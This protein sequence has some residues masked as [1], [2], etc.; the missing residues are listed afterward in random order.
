MSVLSFRKSVD[1]L[2]LVAEQHALLQRTLARFVQATSQYA[3]ELKREHAEA[4]RANLERIQERAERVA[5]A[6][7]ADQLQA[8]FRGELR[9]YL[10]TSQGEIWRMR[11]EMSDVIASMQTFL[12]NSVRSGTNHQQVLRREFKNLD[13]AAQA[14]DL[15]AIRGAVRRATE[16][17]FRSY[18][19]IQRAQ[20]T[21]IAQLQDEIRHLHE[22][23]GYER[24]AALSDPSTGLWNR[25]KLD[26]RIK[27]LLLLNE[28][29]CVYFIGVP[30][31]LHLS[32]RDPR[33]G[34][35]FLRSLAGRLQTAAG[36]NGEFGMAGR[37]SAE[38]FAI[39]FNL[40]LAS[41]PASPAGMQ[42]DLSGDYSIQVE[43]S[44]TSLSVEVA[45]QAIERLRDIPEA[46]FYQELGQAAFRVTIPSP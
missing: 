21:V 27:E 33:I 17:A 18:E 10:D 8:D 16:T 2:D 28:G 3:I 11:S 45:V 22:Q 20:V 5:S 39:V 44:S 24:K 15:T 1:Q 34:P 12:A 4:F 25:S 37:W 23:V 9:A 29:F 26:A 36:G 42:S 40:P 41:A 13:D 38:V 19:E 46:T 35:A 43:G 31:L 6:G 32:R 14:G 7:D 30:R